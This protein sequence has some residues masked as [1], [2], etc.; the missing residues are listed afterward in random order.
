MVASRCRL[1]T[2][3]LDEEV[4]ISGATQLGGRAGRCVST[5]DK[6]PL[7]N[8]RGTGAIEEGQSDRSQQSTVLKWRIPSIETNRRLHFSKTT[9]CKRRLLARPSAVSLVAIG[10]SLPQPVVST[11][12]G[13][14]LA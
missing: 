7:L 9:S 2:L 13:S 12:V 1:R 14:T 4:Q 8:G 3:T 11:R 5:R 6:F 10:R